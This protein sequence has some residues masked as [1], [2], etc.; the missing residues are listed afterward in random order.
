MICAPAL[1]TG[2]LAAI[3]TKPVGTFTATFV[4]AVTWKMAGTVCCDCPGIV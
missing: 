2:E 4:G 3:F 1:F